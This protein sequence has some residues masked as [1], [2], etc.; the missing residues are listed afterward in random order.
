[1][2]DGGSA[3]PSEGWELGSRNFMKIT[4]FYVDTCP[5]ESWLSSLIHRTQRYFLVGRLTATDTLLSWRHD[6]VTFC[7]DDVTL[8]SRRC[9]AGTSLL[10]TQGV[11]DLGLLFR[12]LLDR[13]ARGVVPSEMITWLSPRRS[14]ILLDLL[15]TGQ[16]NGFQSFSLVTGK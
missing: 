8:F 2:L 9:H 11:A 16:E 3:L 10:K 13:S 1:M 12:D 7:C 14:S 6:D 15:F 5:L 4:L